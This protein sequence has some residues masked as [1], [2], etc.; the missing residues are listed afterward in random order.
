LLTES[1]SAVLPTIRSRCRIVNL[2]GEGL[3]ALDD[4]NQ[5]AYLQQAEQLLNELP[6]MPLYKVLRC[7][8]E[9]EKDRETTLAFVGA[10]S[11]V[12]MGAF[13]SSFGREGEY[14]LPAQPA[15]LLKAAEQTQTA[16]EQ[17][18]AN[19]NMRACLDMLFLRLWS[20][21]KQK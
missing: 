18:K 2:R 21:M 1:E 12:L 19:V 9:W 6:A 20:C 16:M 13:K 4:E 17:L 3:A 5:I 15:A 7:A 10:L 14:F 8:T 11:E